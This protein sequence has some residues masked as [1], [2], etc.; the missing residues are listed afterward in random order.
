VESFWQIGEAD[1]WTLQIYVEGTPAATESFF[2]T[3]GASLQFQ[4]GQEIPERPV[5]P[6]GS[7]SFFIA[8][9][10]TGGVTVS[11]CDEENDQGC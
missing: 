8:S 7:S 5:K 3:S 4:Y 1:P 9:N 11:T 10:N 2:G 6:T